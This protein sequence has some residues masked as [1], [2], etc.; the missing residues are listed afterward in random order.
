MSRGIQLGTIPDQ[1]SVVLVSGA[2]FYAT[3][4]NMDGP[5]PEGAVLEL[6]LGNKPPTVWTATITG[7]DAVFD[8]D[9]TTVDSTIAALF[10]TNATRRPQTTKPPTARLFYM[11]GSTEMCW[12][13]GSVGRR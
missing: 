9:T 10:E 2:G 6:R 11:E 12:A 4:R 13:V 7:A 8:V 1:L 3:I 5:W